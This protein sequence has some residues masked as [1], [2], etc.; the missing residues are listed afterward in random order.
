MN[1]AA[2]N[3]K[4]VEQLAKFGFLIT[5]TRDGASIGKAYA[6]VNPLEQKEADTGTS[7][8]TVSEVEL[9]AATK[10]KFD[11][12]PGDVITSKRGNW[13]ITSVEPIEP[14]LVNVAWKLRAA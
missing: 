4:A 11:P 5:V 14:G 3:A 13:R 8:V 12:Q 10:A 7:L 6:V 2:M 1:Y 9:V